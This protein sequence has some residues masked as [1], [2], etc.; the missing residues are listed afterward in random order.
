MTF[1]DLSVQSRDNPRG[2]F[3]FATE[4]FTVRNTFSPDFIDFAT[5][6]YNR[7]DHRIM[8]IN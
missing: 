8:P 3:L 4:H 7:R 5:D 2:A 1:A 6:D